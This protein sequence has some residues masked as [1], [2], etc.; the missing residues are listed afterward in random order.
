MKLLINIVLATL[1]ALPAAAEEKTVP[2]RWEEDRTQVFDGAEIILEDLNWIARPLVVF[3]DTPNDPRFQQQM[4]LLLAGV[5]RLAERD[6][7]LITDTNRAAMTDLRSILRPRGFMMALVG[8]DGRVALRKP[9]PWS[10]RELSRSID[11]MPLRQQ[12]MADRRL[13]DE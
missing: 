11:K 1:I 3:S 12:E 6:V 8:K 13:T 7:I 9:A 10:V 2:E 4:D 5:D